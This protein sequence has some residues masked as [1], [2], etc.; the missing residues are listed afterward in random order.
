MGFEELDLE[1]QTSE[2]KIES[3][4]SETRLTFQGVTNTQILGNYDSGLHLLQWTV[5]DD[6]VL[7]DFS[8][9]TNDAITIAKIT[10]PTQV[11]TMSIG[12]KNTYTAVGYPMIMV[13]GGKLVGPVKCDTSENALIH[14]AAERISYCVPLEVATNEN[15][16]VIVEEIAVATGTDT[17]GPLD[18]LI[19]KLIREGQTP[20][21]TMES[22]KASEIDDWRAKGDPD[23]RTWKAY[24][25][26]DEPLKAID[27]TWQVAY[28]P[29]ESAALVEKF[30]IPTMSGLQPDQALAITLNDMFIQ[31]SEQL[32]NTQIERARTFKRVT[33]APLTSEQIT[34]ESLATQQAT[35]KAEVTSPPTEPDTAIAVEVTV[36]SF[37]TP[38]GTSATGAS[39]AAASGFEAGYSTATIPT[40]TVPTAGATP[41]PSTSTAAIPATTATA[42]GPTPTPSTTTTT[43][44]GTGY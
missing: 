19:I 33:Q 31:M 22:A 26:T 7:D 23:E 11:G 28:E 41:T 1:L 42:T 25:F 35:V 40:T 32:V 16:D 21:V 13:T 15:N 43:P 34:P 14:A 12:Y 37:S 24:R 36:P 9:K 17:E 4:F 18:R 5:A 29:N 8:G 3:D 44:G 6:E 30:G 38:T 10:E 27:N 39:S 2:N 20:E